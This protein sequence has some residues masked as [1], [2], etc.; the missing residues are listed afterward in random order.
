[1][2]RTVSILLVAL[3]LLFAVPTVAE[4]SELQAGLYVSEAGTELLYLDEKG[5][6]VLNLT[7]NDQYLTN[8]VLW[9]Q[10]SLEVERADTPFL[11]VDQ[12]LIITYDGKLMALRYKGEGEAYALG[13]LRGT[14]FAGTYASEDGRTLILTA[15]GQGA[16][17]DA[18][19]EQPIFWGSI[20]PYWEGVDGLSDEDCFALFG[21]YLSAMKF[22]DDSVTVNMENEGEVLF[23]RAST[24]I[25]APAVTGEL[26]YGYR[27]SSDGQNI[28]L[29]PFLTTMGMD[30]KSIYLEFRADG[31]GSMAFMDEAIELTW[32]AEAIAA[33]GETIPYTREGGHIFITIGGE[34]IEFAPAAELEA[35]LNG[36]ALDSKQTSGTGASELN[37][38]VGTWNFTKAKAMG[39]EIPASMM[40][41]SMTLVLN[42]DGTASLSTDDS[43]NDLEWTMEVDGTVSLSVAGTEIFTLT[44]DGTVLTLATGAADVEMIFEKE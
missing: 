20:A 39:M 24:V 21:S 9:T 22:G 38:L 5:V 26:Y 29:I 15:D 3:L 33:D 37:G 12:V 8:G 16:Y 27:M 30:P 36:N 14:E 35:L 11:F 7:R 25:E 13:H 28:D 43:T 32:T 2:K 23:R 18:A 1:M 17:T 42:A 41:T 19:G 40:G 6:G 31:T 34:S 4:T 44:Y 10:N